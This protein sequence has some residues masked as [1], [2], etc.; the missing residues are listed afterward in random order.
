MYS[1]A[2]SSGDGA[3]LLEQESP[4]LLKGTLLIFLISIEASVGNLPPK[5]NVTIKLRYVMQLPLIK[6]KVLFFL[7]ILRNSNK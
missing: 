3:Y 1:D 7:P 6:E 2:I 4:T 5:T